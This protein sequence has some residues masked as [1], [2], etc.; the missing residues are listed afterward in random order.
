VHLFDD[1]D[2]TAKY[3]IVPD[4]RNR[5]KKNEVEAYFRHKVT[6]IDEEFVYVENLDTGKQVRIPADFV[7]L[8]TGYR[9]DE[10]FLQQVGL[11]NIHTKVT[12]PVSTWGDR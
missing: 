8:M 1:F 2:S 9:P 12:C 3:W 6:R 11:T 10:D 5:V 7:F 4:I